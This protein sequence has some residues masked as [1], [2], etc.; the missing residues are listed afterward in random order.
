[1]RTLDSR[2]AAARN[3]IVTKPLRAPAATLARAAA[4]N[5]LLKGN[6]LVLH[7]APFVSIIRLLLGA[8]LVVGMSSCGGQG[9]A[10]GSTPPP[11]PGS[12]KPGSKSGSGNGGSN[13]GGG[14]PAPGNITA[15]NH[16]I[17]MFQENRSFDHYFAH[18]N[19][20][21]KANGWGGANDVD[22]LDALGTVPTNPADASAPVRWSSTNATSVII[23]GAP[24][25]STTG[26]MSVMPSTATLY[27]AV[28]TSST[29]EAA[30]ASVVVG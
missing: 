10:P 4:S 5:Q 23:N 3:C 14:T 7:R 18:L 24:A 22:T 28:A 30:Q 16:I 19:S 1:M 25:G 12:S 2:F 9:A 17:F 29:G 11:N 20:Y 27:T 8:S 26:G 15:L 13:S 21:R 6:T